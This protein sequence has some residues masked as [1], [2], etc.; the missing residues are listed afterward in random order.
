M[1]AA[2]VA[3]ESITSIAARYGVSH[4]RVSQRLQRARGIVSP[5]AREASP[6]RRVTDYEGQR[7]EVVEERPTPYG[8]SVL[9]GWPQLRPRG[10]SPVVILTRQLAAHL[11]AQASPA[12]ELPISTTAVHRL[13]RRLGLDV[14]AE[15]YRWWC[16][17]IHDLGTLTLEQFADKHLPPPH[18]G[19]GE[20]LSHAWISVMRQR[21]LGADG[22]DD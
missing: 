6:R 21:L 16:D 3:G 17:R 13:R 18:I 10:G 22:T 12:G 15:Q 14:R 1:L 11:R 4:Q 19:R 8:W 5:R 7:F 9:L 20:R 2:H